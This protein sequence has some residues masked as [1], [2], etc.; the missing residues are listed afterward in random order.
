MSVGYQES[1]ELACPA[2]NVAFEAPVWLILDAQEAPEAVAALRRGEL[3]VVT[4]PSCGHRGPAGAP[5]LFHDAVRRRVIFA[6]APGVPEYAWRDQA[7]DLHALLVGSLPEEQRR[8]YLGEVEIVQDL[9]GIARL[10]ERMERRPSEPASHVTPPVTGEAVAGRGASETPAGSPT[11]DPPPLLAAVEAMLAADGPEEFEAV[12]ARHPVLLD[13]GADTALAQLIEVALEQREFAI[14]DSLRNAR[15]L[16]ARLTEMS[17]SHAARPA[18]APP[19]D[20]LPD[21]AVQ[22]L[23]RTRTDAELEAVCAEHP[24]LL[25]LEADGLLARRVDQA[26]DEG[27]ERLAQALEERREA[28]A[29]RRPAAAS[30]ADAASLDEAIE[31]LLVADGEEALIEV[32]DRYPVLLEEAAAD[33]LWQFA[34]EARASGDEELARYAVACREL[35][36]RV[37]ADLEP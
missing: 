13:P 17:R 11:E 14:A 9:G 6:P 3:N 15:A 28:L 33:A 5:L 31:A 30:E 26:L 25:R 27:N 1:T 4:C 20:D 36:R 23:L 22:A 29:R 7:R 18:P 21:A 8:P 16:L 12:L 32:L 24:V 10:L 2:C 35:L 34:A 19:V 37:R